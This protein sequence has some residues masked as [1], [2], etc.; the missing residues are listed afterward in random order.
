M[1]ET[2]ETRKLKSLTW[3]PTPN[4]HDGKGYRRLMAQDDP[5]NLFAAFV[6]IVG[7]ASK[8]PTRGVLEDRD[9]PL[10]AQDL[11]FK[12]GFPAQ[13]FQRAFDI[14]SN[15]QVKIQWIVATGDAENPLE[16]AGIA[17]E[18]PETSSA[19]GME[20]NGI[21]GK[22]RENNTPPSQNDTMLSSAEIME[23]TNLA[24]QF[25]KKSHWDDDGIN[26]PVYRVL[27]NLVDRGDDVSAAIEKH[28]VPDMKP[29]QLREI[30]HPALKVGGK[31]HTYSKGFLEE[32]GKG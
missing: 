13:H 23:L 15:P 12:T 3:V 17:A 6:L 18:S 16:S 9:G 10:D 8:M 21:E 32:L 20:W 4:K 25:I 19:N 29:W 11:S 30:L 2:S 31:Q 27:K 22:G 1:Y 5:G 26:K 24:N 14:L 28:V 7:V